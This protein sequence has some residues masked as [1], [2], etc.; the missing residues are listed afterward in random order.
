M[1]R[2]F[3]NYAH[4]GASE[5]YPENTLSSFYAGIDMGALGIETDVQKTKDGVLVL[6]HDDNTKRVTGLDSAVSH[7]TYEELMTLTVTNPKTGRQDKILTLDDFIKYIAYRDLTY[8]IEIKQK[9]ISVEVMK[10]LADAGLRDRVTITSFIYEELEAAKDADMGFRL[11][12]L[13]WGK[14]DSARIEGLRAIGAYEAC[15]KIAD[16]TEHELMLIYESGF[17]CR[18]WGAN[19]EELMRRAVDMGTCGITVNFPDKLTEYLN[20]KKAN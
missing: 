17:A 18:A 8:A 5:Y 2:K 1:R 3:I 10:R 6:F 20:A 14:T 12:W 19:N 9:G 16:L 11:G 4:R 7:L 13:Y 15:P